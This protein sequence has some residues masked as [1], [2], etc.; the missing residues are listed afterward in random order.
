MKYDLP[1]ELFKML[2]ININK[3]R[4]EMRVHTTDVQV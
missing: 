4:W 3:H 1:L 2:G